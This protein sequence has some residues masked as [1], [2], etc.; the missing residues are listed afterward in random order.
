MGRATQFLSARG[1]LSFS[2][3]VEASALENSNLR[4]RIV[5]AECEVEEAN[6]RSGADRKRIA[7]LEG[8]NGAV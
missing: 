2:L 4:V 6:R 3:A 1:F 5:R 8:E 7:E